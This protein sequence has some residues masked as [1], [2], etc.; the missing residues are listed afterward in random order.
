MKHLPEDSMRI[1][2]LLFLAVGVWAANAGAQAP[3]PLPAS[4]DSVGRILQAPG[5]FA[6]GYYRYNLP[7]TDLTVKVG[8]VIVAP[9]LALGSWAGFS[10]TPAKAMVMGDLVLTAGELA[11]VQQALND[12]HVGITGV[13]NHLVGEEPDIIYLHFGAEGA[14]VDLAR[15]LS[16]VLSLTATPQPVA[17]AKPAALAIDTTRIFT[18]LGKSGRAQGNVVQLSFMLVPDT[19]KQNGMPLVAAQAYG[20]PINLQAVSDTRVVATGDF[21]VR[22]SKVQPVLSALAAGLITATAVH[23]HLIGET[24]KVYYIHFWGDG[25]LA[26][27]LDGLRAALDAAK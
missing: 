18:K 2:T 3:A 6:G 17:P 7:R 11:P 14:A 23:T 16:T 19:V 22:E 1:L 4:W 15:R 12:Q 9:G 25:P 21:S 26:D 27:V 8:D 20:T 10:G 13:R 24:P 5:T